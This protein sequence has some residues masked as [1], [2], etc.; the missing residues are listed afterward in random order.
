MADVEPN[1]RGL[2][3][4]ARQTEHSHGVEDDKKVRR[5]DNLDAMLVMFTVAML[6]SYV[7]PTPLVLVEKKCLSVWLGTFVAV[8]VVSCLINFVTLRILNKVASVKQMDSY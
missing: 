6:P 3:E 8:V 1:D 4:V 2:S 5:L 7:M